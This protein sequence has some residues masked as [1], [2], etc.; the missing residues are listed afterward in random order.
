MRRISTLFFLF[1]GLT[2]FSQSLD[3]NRYKTS[4]FPSQSTANVQYGTAPQWVWPYWS[5]DL[6][7]DVFQ[8]NGD[9][10]QKRP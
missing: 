10:N 6:F 5:E 1:T 9:L 8:P 2:T 4:I 7:L 3:T